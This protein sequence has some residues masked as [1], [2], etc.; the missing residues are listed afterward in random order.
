MSAPRT[1]VLWVPD[2]PVHA[3]RDPADPAGAPLAL[4]AQHRVTAC[5]AAA[6]AEGVRVGLREREAQ[7]RCPSLA[8]RAHDPE[9]DAR[10]F[11]PVL[12]ALEEAVPGI[13]ALRPG[14]CACRARGPARYYG[15]E[16]R[17]AAA[18]LAVLDGLGVPDARVGV[19]DGR[20]A[21]EQA[22]RS[23]SS[24]AGAEAPAPGVRVVP[25]GGSAAFLAPLPVSRAA[26]P[27]FAHVLEGLGIRTLGALA[28]LPEA[29]VRQRFGAE[30]LAAHRRASASAPGHG[31]PAPTGGGRPRLPVELACERAFE[32]P[33]DSAEHLAFACVAL[34]DRFV[35]GLVDEGLV[36][37]ALRVE[38]TDDTGARHEREWAHP[39]RFTAT[40]V[41]D[42][43]R[44]QAMQSA[45]ATERGGAG[46]ARVRVLPTHTD[47]AAA[48]EPGL[49]SAEP[50]ARVHHHLSRAQSRLG[51]DAVGTLELAGGRLLAER[52]RFVPWGTAR[53]TATARGAGS[54]R[55]AARPER[56][57]AGPWPGALD[58]P[59]P[60]RVLDPPE[61]AELT[62]DTGR[63]VG[64]DGDDLLTA[65]PHALRVGGAALPAPVAGWSRPWPVRERWWAGA[66]ERFRLQV[67]L[68]NGD[69][70][71]LLHEAGR[72]LAEGRY[73]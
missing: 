22:A 23:G 70:W 21:A 32:P 17:A 41:V 55:R 16:A 29:S 58:A 47:R 53:G 45:R 51:H 59:T 33:I 61:P 56:G 2:W 68:A 38:L 52:Q 3:H 63:P 48:H 4:T 71:L 18:L 10:A 64:I 7:V 12:A 65:A 9:R 15:D 26:A 25:P 27:A 20:F 1:L 30:G 34:A 60:T 72:W 11:L 44:W 66:P 40:E 62:D 28:A 36:C 24:A 57:P 50:D 67:A 6:R 14:L 46:I 19:A 8:L 31:E 5:S 42:R 73:D 54:P 43:V 69:A 39:R 37:T 49:W 13:E 35:A